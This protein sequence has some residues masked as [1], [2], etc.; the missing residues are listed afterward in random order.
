M[1]EDLYT[2]YRVE[3]KAHFAQYTS[4]SR[5]GRINSNL[6]YFYNAKLILYFTVS[7]RLFVAISL[8]FGL[9]LLI[10]RFSTGSFIKNKMYI[11]IFPVNVVFSSNGFIVRFGLPHEL[12]GYLTRVRF[13]LELCLEGKYHQR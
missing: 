6:N 1:L 3:V 13:S 10:I 12:F 9:Y 5:E 8:H 4:S 2:L 11:F 7:I